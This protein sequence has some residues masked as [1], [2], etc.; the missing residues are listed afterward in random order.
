MKTKYSP[1]LQYRLIKDWLA[2]I[3]QKLAGYVKLA[4][5]T[6]QIIV[7]DIAFGFGKKIL[8]TAS[9]D[10]QH[11][12][13]GIGE[14]A[15]GQQTEIGSESIPLCLNHREVAGWSDKRIAVNG[16]LQDNTEFT[17]KVAYYSDVSKQVLIFNEATAQYEYIP[18]E[19]LN[20]DTQAIIEETAIDRKILEKATSFLLPHSLLFNEDTNEWEII[21]YSSDEWSPNYILDYGENPPTPPADNNTHIAIIP[22]TDSDTEAS[23]FVNIL[24]WDGAAWNVATAHVVIKN[25]D[26]FSEYPSTDGYYWFGGKFN[27]LDFQVDLS[28]YYTKNEAD[29]L[30]ANKV[31]KVAGK[32]L[33]T[34]DF[35]NDWLALLQF[36]TATQTLSSLANIVAT[37]QNIYAAISAN[38]TFSISSVS[39]S[40]Q[41]VNITVKN[42]STAERSITMP[43]GST[44]VMMGAPVIVLAA[45]SYCEINIIKNSTTGLYHI[46][47]LQ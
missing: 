43:T 17:D 41:P 47:V 40:N 32:G 2:D 24:V 27:R 26:L 22:E 38:Q 29:L 31:D 37:C 23:D 13:I 10:T 7:S 44:Y 3:T 39:L 6:T 21:A 9:D 16:K 14:Y 4:S 45:N 19:T 5:E 42:T 20:N 30:L 25:G 11:E 34:N 33:S 15:T 36:I 35:T 46:T 1:L 12:L 18:F 28:V 8:G